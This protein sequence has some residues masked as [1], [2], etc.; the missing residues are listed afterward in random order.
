MATVDLERFLGHSVEAIEQGR[1]LGPIGI[2]KKFDD[3]RVVLCSDQD[4]SGLRLQLTLAVKD[5]DGSDTRR[6]DYWSV[7]SNFLITLECSIARPCT[8]KVAMRPS[9]L[10]VGD[11]IEVNNCPAP[12]LAVNKRQRVIQIETKVWLSGKLEKVSTR[13]PW[14]DTVIVLVELDSPKK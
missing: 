12:V 8:L 2:L 4:L 6:F 11:A 9:A 13:I 10:C 1:G 3:R 14:P 5:L 7:V